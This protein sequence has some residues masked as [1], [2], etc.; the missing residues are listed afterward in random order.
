MTPKEAWSGV[1]LSVKHFRVFRSIAYIHVPDTQR[2]K[3][4]D[5]STRCIL[6]G[7]SEE[8]KAY[9]LYDPKNK[10]VLIS[11]DVVFEES[12]GWN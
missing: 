8:S 3:L 11:K 6:L 12:Q 9:K 4:D 10:K 5:K 2:K 7:L 1:K